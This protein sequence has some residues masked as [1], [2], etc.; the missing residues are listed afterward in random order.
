MRG[1][2]QSTHPL[3]AAPMRRLRAIRISQAIRDDLL[4]PGQLG[5]VASVHR[6]A[7]NVRRGDRMLTVALDSVGGLPNGLSVASPMPLDQL[8]LCPGMTVRSHGSLSVPA[9]AVMIDLASA[10]SWSPTMANLAQTSARE[11]SGYVAGTIAL[12]AADVGG[13][14]LGPLITLLDGTPT[15][16]PS[17]LIQTAA[18]ALAD[19]VEGLQSGE[20]RRAVEPASSLVGLGPGATP[21]GDDLLV[22]LSAGLLAICHP[23]AR[24]FARQVADAAAGRTTALAETFLW[25]AG[26]G[27]FAE[28]VQRTAGAVLSGD[29]PRMRQAVRDEL[30]WGASSGADLLGGML[31]GIIVDDPDLPIRLRV[32]SLVA[33]AA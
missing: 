29:E 23:T 27:E 20:V 1:L 28:R 8:G 13:M 2:E 6:S 5:T 15:R 24:P 9:A 17:R 33:A 22:G 7:I 4:I 3:V 10:G 16:F 14:G 21:S 25:H 31:I 30:A 11:R 32:A 12:A 26:R 19:V 18:G